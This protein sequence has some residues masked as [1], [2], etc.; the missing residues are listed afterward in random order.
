MI[1]LDEYEKKICRLAIQIFETERVLTQ[2]NISNDDA[3][4]AEHLLDELT[5]EL[6]DCIDEH[7]KEFMALKQKLQGL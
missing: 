1:V 7:P 6:T 4:T 3:V 5:P 2:E